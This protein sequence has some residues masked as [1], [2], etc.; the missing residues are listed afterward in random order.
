MIFPAGCKV[1]I[2]LDKKPAIFKPGETVT[3]TVSLTAQEPIKARGFFI[4]LKG[5]ESYSYGS[6][7]DR[8][9]GHEVLFKDSKKLKEEGE[10]IGNQTHKFQFKIPSDAAPSIS[11]G[12]LLLSLELDRGYDLKKNT[13][14]TLA[15]YKSRS[16]KLLSSVDKKKLASFYLQRSRDQHASIKW[17][18]EA[19]L[20]VALKLDPRMT[21]Q[22]VVL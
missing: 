20:D 7:D 19:K 3:G 5:V 14:N 4:S 9:S 21:Y 2:K 8:V 10:F 16:D 12:L 1:E 6:R 11:D 13:K 22:I 18:I 15:Y 17:Y